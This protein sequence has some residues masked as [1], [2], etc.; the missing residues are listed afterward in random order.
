MKRMGK[1]GIGLC[2][3]LQFDIGTYAMEI[4]EVSM[5]QASRELTEQERTALKNFLVHQFR[6]LEQDPS[7]D[8]NGHQK[9]A[10]ERVLTQFDE[11]RYDTMIA[12]LIA[13][14]YDPRMVLKTS[15]LRV[16]MLEGKLQ[17]TLWFLR[18]IAGL[19]WFFERDAK[20]SRKN[21]KWPELQD[22][23]DYLV[24]LANHLEL[25][26]KKVFDTTV[27][28]DAIDSLQRHVE[29]L[30]TDSSSK[31]FKMR[32]EELLERLKGIH[33]TIVNKPEIKVVE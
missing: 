8:P 32:A 2:M 13:L 15:A 21:K 26:L 20:R 16:Y 19:D 4:N 10:L 18:E 17:Q 24:S 3:V 33:A 1:I 11:Y 31:R 9:E 29:S 22:K 23:L 28:L 5:H 12:G 7:L 6:L 25:N 30:I 14:G 27:L